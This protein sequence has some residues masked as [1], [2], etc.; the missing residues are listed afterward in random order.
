MTI[1]GCL[2]KRQKTQAQQVME[3]SMANQ[4]QK[5]TKKTLITEKLH[6]VFVAQ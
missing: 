1:L 2:E 4:C 3:P 6:S 5:W